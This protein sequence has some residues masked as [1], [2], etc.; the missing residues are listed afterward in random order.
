MKFKSLG[1]AATAAALF[2]TALT[3]TVAAAGTAAAAP[4]KD[5]SKAIVNVKAKETVKV[6]TSPKTSATALGIWGKGKRG[7]I[8][9][10]GKA[11]K[12]GSYTACGKK[13]NMWYY[14]GDKVNG[15]VP[16]TCIN[17]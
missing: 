2:A 7:G 12:G 3:G 10:D 14:G 11:Y 4:P 1:T 6:R 9:N 5:C 17:W 13:S 8:C 15:W 16:K